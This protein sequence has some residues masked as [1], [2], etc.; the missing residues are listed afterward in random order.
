MSPRLG[1]VLALALAACVARAAA[2]GCSNE[3]CKD[4]KCAAGQASRSE[5]AAWFRGAEAATAT[6]APA[7]L[8]ARRPFFR[9]ATHTM[10][11]LFCTLLPAD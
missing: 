2:L 1:L 7:A 10:G 8:A 11:T 4:Y 5:G 3:P 6:A 9:R